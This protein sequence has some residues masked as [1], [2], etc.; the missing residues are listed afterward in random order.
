MAIVLDLC[1]RGFRLSWSSGFCGLG[2][3]RRGGGFTLGG[4][5]LWLLAG[6]KNR[7]GLG[8]LKRLAF[9]IMSRTAGFADCLVGRAA[10]PAGDDRQLLLQFAF[11]EDL[12]RLLEVG[13]QALVLER[14]GIDRRSLVENIQIGK[15]DDM[16]SSLEIVV[17]ETALG[18]AAEDGGLSAFMAALDVGADAGLGAFVAAAAGLALAAGF[19]AAFA[20]CAACSAERV[21]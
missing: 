3:R 21:W 8:K 6:D 16:E 11:A 14:Q 13:D 2:S 20:Q 1:G 12:Y 15:I 9:G 18:E 10:V 5:L 19:A 4:F 17:A 7:L